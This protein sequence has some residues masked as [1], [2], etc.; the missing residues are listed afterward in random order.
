MQYDLVVVGAGIVGLAHA[1]AA[2]QR[3]LRVVVIDRDAQA[4]GASI[5]NFGLVVVSG[6]EPGLSRRRAE[7][8]RAAWLDL[9][10]KAG[11]EILHRGKLV[12]AQ[13]PE[14]L[15][16]LEAFSAEAD[17]GDCKMLTAS[18]VVAH[19]PGLDASKIVGGFYSPF[20]LRVES[21]EV[22][23]KLASFL[24][25]RHGVEFRFGVAVTAIAP[26][27]VET[28]HGTLRAKKVVVCPGDD[29]ATLYPEQVSSYGV[30]R[31]KLQ[32]LRLANPGFK[33]SSAL[34]SDLSLLRYAGYAAMPE[35]ASLR[36]RLQ[37]E[38]APALENGVHLIV[39]QSADG[40]L[41][42]GDS[43]HYGPTPDP[44]ASEAVDA[45]ILAEFAKLFG[46]ATPAVQARWTGTYASASNHES[47]RD[48]PH[49][50]VRLV[51]VTSGTGA[52]TGF[53]I[54]EET[55]ADLFGA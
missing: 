45:M 44:F 28:S 26:P 16:V 39:V 22:L 42:I 4:N 15:A 30:R 55:V 8:T 21:R 13:R 48:A 1:F 9:A 38:V 32:M 54:G 53:A 51:M 37:G 24:A 18:E 17:A 52:S 5:R 20:E 47:F 49:E 14:A 43:H 31:C 2:A 50:D 46:G 41:V 6:Q 12:A 29:L 7:R 34:V 35:A 10:E 3:G 36:R 11:I 33:L 40:S 27:S 25:E 19:Q 23:P